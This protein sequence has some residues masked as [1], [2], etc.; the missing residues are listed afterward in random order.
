MHAV[1]CKVHTIP[2]WAQAAHGGRRAC[3]RRHRSPRLVK[4]KRQPTHSAARCSS[5]EALAAWASSSRSG[6]FSRYFTPCSV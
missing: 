3:S 1:S 2:V 6:R 4:S 5:R